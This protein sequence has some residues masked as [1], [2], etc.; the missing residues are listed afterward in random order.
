[1]SGYSKTANLIEKKLSEFKV[2]RQEGEI[3]PKDFGFGKFK[4]YSNK[5]DSEDLINLIAVQAKKM[6]EERK[7]D[8]SIRSIDPLSSVDED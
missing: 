6:D 7:S 4:D 2:V 5:L 1:M 3:Q 8:V